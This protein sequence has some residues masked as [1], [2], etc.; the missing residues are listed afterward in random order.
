MPELPDIILIF[1]LLLSYL[2]VPL[3][4][5]PLSLLLLLPFLLYNLEF[6]IELCEL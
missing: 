2:G 1:K 4:N 6:S 3:L 5:L